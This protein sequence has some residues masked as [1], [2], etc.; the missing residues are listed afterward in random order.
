MVGTT[1]FHDHVP[2]QFIIRSSRNYRCN[3]YFGNKSRNVTISIFDFITLC[4]FADAIKTMR[5]R[6]NYNCAPAK[7]LLCVAFFDTFEKETERRRRRTHC[8]TKDATK[9]QK[10]KTEDPNERKN[11]A[12]G[13]RVRNFL[14]VFHTVAP[15]YNY[16]AEDEFSILFIRATESPSGR[17][18]LEHTRA[19]IIMICNTSKRCASIVRLFVLHCGWWN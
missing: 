15:N 17:R 3:Y 13:L 19:F 7:L 8:S 16:D 18:L 6:S 4:L 1:P 9:E 14:F 12:V 2:L 11:G 5:T 10:K